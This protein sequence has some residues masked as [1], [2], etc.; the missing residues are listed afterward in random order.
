MRSPIFLGELIGIKM[1]LEIFIDF[2]DVDQKLCDIVAPNRCILR[3][4][5]PNVLKGIPRSSEPCIP[6]LIEKLYEPSILQPLIP[7]RE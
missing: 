6:V 7:V 5:G 3:K 2:Y 1:I 4:A